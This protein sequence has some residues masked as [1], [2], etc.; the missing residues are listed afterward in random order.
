MMQTDKEF[1]KVREQANANG[2]KLCPVVPDDYPGM[3]LDSYVNRVQTHMNA[4][5][6]KMKKALE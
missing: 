3:T 2:F 4:V 6:E 1:A 5:E